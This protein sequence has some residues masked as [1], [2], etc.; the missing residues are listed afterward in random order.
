LSQEN[1]VLTSE[2][3]TS[4]NA[5]IEV[6]RTL[7]AE[8]YYSE[9]FY[10]A[11]R[12]RIFS[13]HWVAVLFDFDVAEPGQA[14]PFELCGMPLL[15]VRG[16]DERIRVFHN[17]VPYDGC[18]AVTEPACGLEHIQT[19]YHGWIYDL[20][21][22]LKKIPFW[23]GTPE[24]DLQSVGQ[25]DTDLVEVH[26]E[27]FL[28]TV[29]VNLSKQPQP[30]QDYIAP[31]TRQFA[32]YDFD[33]I[34][35]ATDTSGQAIV[36]RAV[37]RCNWKIF[38]DIDGPNV[39]HEHFVHRDYRNSR[40]HPRVSDK[41]EKTYRE[42]IDGFLI[43]LGFDHSDF[44]ETYGEIDPSD[45]HLG[46]NGVLPD[47]AAFVDLYPAMSFS[48][49]PTFIEIGINLPDGA[50]KTVDRRMYLL[51]AAS[52]T[53]ENAAKR[54]EI[55]GFFGS[56]APEDNAISEAVQKAAY[57]PVYTQRFFSP[58]WD[59]MRHQFHKWVAAD[60]ARA[61]TGKGE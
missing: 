32:E 18:L 56:V 43:G 58:F 25:F 37:T 6:A 13:K 28:H 27:T 30:F 3:L 1:C 61:V 41:G 5:P 48:I 38:F 2:Q 60:L 19:P 44:V 14:L 7:P 42:I 31:I 8:S 54:E 11:E 45:P 16:L 50:D 46:R 4:I 22:Q 53:P 20:H 15:A 49:G 36:P 23:D 35:V 26:C 17:V 51:P 33:T 39:L 12:D 29:F 10:K 24:G 47:K 59:R 21:G 52:A 57:S 34:A 40:L 55:Y 9:H